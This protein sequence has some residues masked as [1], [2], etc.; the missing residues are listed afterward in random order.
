M[1][2]IDIKYLGTDNSKQ[3]YCYDTF[4]VTLDNNIKDRIGVSTLW[5][6]NNAIKSVFNTT[7]NECVGSIDNMN[8]AYK[9]FCEEL[10]K[11]HKS[12]FKFSELL[13]DA[14]NI[15]KKNKNNNKQ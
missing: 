3:N 12:T 4:E 5:R 15:I 9:M 7:I 14:N 8:D 13:A 2:V 10:N 11:V 1:K 6:P